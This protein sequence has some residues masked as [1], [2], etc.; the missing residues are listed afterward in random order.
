MKVI[1]SSVF[2]ALIW[3][4]TTVVEGAVEHGE[5]TRPSCLGLYTKYDANAGVDND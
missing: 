2:A 1:F 3:A 5:D 4:S